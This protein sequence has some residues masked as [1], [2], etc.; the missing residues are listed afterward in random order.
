LTWMVHDDNLSLEVVSVLSWLS[1][2]IGGDV[3]S[4]DIRAGKT[5]N[6]ETNIVSRN[7][8]G[9][10][11]VMHLD[12]FAIGGGTDWSEADGHV[13]LDD[14]GFDSTDWDCSDTRD[15]VDILEW[16]SEWL[17]DW[18][19][20]W[21]EGIKG[22]KE[23]WSLVPWHVGGW[24][25]HVVTN[26]TGNWD[27]WNVLDLV[28]N[29]F[30]IEGDLR[31]DFVVS[32]FFVVGTLGVHLVA[33]DDHLLD[34]HGESEKS[35]LSGLTFLGPSGLELTRWGSDHEDGDISLGGTGNHVLNEISVSWGINDGED[36]FGGLEFPESDIDGDTS[37]SLG[38]EFIKYPSVFERSFTHFF[39]FLLELGNGSLINTTAFVDEMTGG[40][41]F[42]RVDMT[43]NDEVDVN[44]F[45]TH[46]EVCVLFESII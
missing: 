6:V 28:T 40:S 34:T 2:G 1:L 19:L 44:F 46:L 23:I 7:S 45:F 4:L 31:F 13:W 20:W 18:S 11:L 12:G 38:L 21:L 42:T 10:L 32:L 37:F 24:L 35:V 36:G 30:K 25:E 16:E 26:P 43:N 9:D 27:E 15:L 41:G 29:L 8:F 14:T 3:T 17:E 22:F 5:L 39:G 33:A